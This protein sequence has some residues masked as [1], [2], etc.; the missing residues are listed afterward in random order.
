MEKFK[1]KQYYLSEKEKSTLEIL[2]EIGIAEEDWENIKI[3]AQIVGEDFGMEV[4]L[5]PPYLED[6]NP[7]TGKKEK[8]PYVAFEDPEEGSI[9]FN[10]LFV[11]ENPRKSKR[12]AAHEGAHR[13]ITRGYKEIGLNREFIEKLQSPEYLGFSSFNNI[14]LEDP[15]VNNWDTKKFPGLKE[16]NQE[17]YDEQLKEENAQF[18]T[19]EVNLIISKLG[20]YPRYAEAAS[21]LLR[22]WHKGEYSKKLKPEVKKFLNRCQKYATEYQNTIPPTDRGLKESE[23]IEIA[24]KCFEIYHNYIWPEV[25]KLVDMDLQTEKQ[26]QMM[27]E[28]RQ[29]QKELEQKRQEIEQAK[30]QGDK[31][32]QEKLQGEIEGLEKELSLFNELPEDVRE[33]LQEQI[34][35]AI[36]ETIQRLNREIEEKQREIEKTKQKQEQLDKEIKDLERKAKQASGKEKEELEKQIQEKKVENLFQEMKQKQEEN[37]LK[38]IQDTLDDIQ[39]GQELPYPEDKLSEKTKHELEKLFNKLPKKKQQEIEEKAREQLED[40]EDVVN[41]ETEGKLNKDKPERHKERRKKVEVEKEAAR[42]SQKGRIEEERIKKELERI[43]EEKMTLYERERAK[44]AGLI[45]DLYYRL[46]RILKPEEYGGEETGYPT[47][48]LLDITRVMQAERDV[49]QKYKLWIRETAPERKDYRFWHLIDLSGSMEGKKIEETFKGF[50]IVGEAVDR[51]EDLNSDIITVHQGIT[52]FHNRIFPFKGMNERFTKEIENKLSTMLERTKDYDAGT[53]TYSATLFAL[54]N[55]KQ[56]LGETANFLLTFSD[57][58]PNYDIRDKLKKLLKQGKEERKRLKIKIGLIWLGEGEDEQKLQELVKEYGYD[59]GLVMSAIKP[60][61]GKT[62][63]EA[64]ADL[65]EDIV[66]NPEKC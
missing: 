64:L 60:E 39:S 42:K 37:T 65:L 27:T 41:K 8:I 14:G 24:R 57:G 54:E 63:A 62:F 30:K 56:N 13:A 46:R 28:F 35:K 16:L 45:D 47:G 5:G 55:L 12:I 23:V 32:K 15:R 33:E 1:K 48:K 58:E 22:F 29:K 18:I 40:F 10:P 4:K 2:K 26:R 38:K 21:E 20:R 51:I 52:G 49:E 36:Q 66:K 53:N 9:T 7:L 31:Q 44:V 6:F 3:I 25:K 50:I 43:L 17:V 34:N 59:F 19:P 61:G 11:K